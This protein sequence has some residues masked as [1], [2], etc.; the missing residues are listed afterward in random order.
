MTPATDAG[1]QA[2]TDTSVVSTDSS[3]LWKSVQAGN[4]TF[5]V[6]LVNNDDTPLET[7]VVSSVSVTV[8]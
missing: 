7:P 5:S 4:H 2:T 8:Q 1:T 6:Q 3:H